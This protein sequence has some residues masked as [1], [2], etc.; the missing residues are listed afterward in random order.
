VP[1]SLDIVTTATVTAITPVT[2]VT[3]VTTATKLQTVTTV[4]IVTAVV[5][6]VTASDTTDTTDTTV[7][8]SYCHHCHRFTIVTTLTTATTVTTFTT[9]ASTTIT[10]HH[11]S[12]SALSPLSAPT[13]LAL[14]TTIIHYGSGIG[15]TAPVIATTTVVAGLEIARLHAQLIARLHFQKTSIRCDLFFRLSCLVCCLFHLFFSLSLLF[16][17][18]EKLFER[19]VHNSSQSTSFS[20]AG[21]QFFFLAEKTEGWL[22]HAQER[23]WLE[24]VIF[25]CVYGARR[26]ARTLSSAWCTSQ[27]PSPFTHA[28]REQV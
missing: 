7:T 8:L 16:G 26:E 17:S 12:L 1:A 25:C 2:T 18:D 4:T 15:S 23:R 6:P 24:R 13:T 9:T 3:V 10:C 5:T 28:S 11:S 19:F 14:T 21:E 20:G 22:A 27:R